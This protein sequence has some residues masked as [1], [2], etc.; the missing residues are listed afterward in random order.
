MTLASLQKY[1][2]RAI[3]VMNVEIDDRDALRAMGGLRVARGDGGVVEKAEAHRRRAFGVMAGR[4]RRDKGV[5]EAPAHH[6]IDRESRAARGAH[7][8]FQRARRHHRVRVEPRI[9]LLGAASSMAAT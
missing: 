4:P 1:I 9:A 8:R 6:F 3:A 2:L 5:G 7:R